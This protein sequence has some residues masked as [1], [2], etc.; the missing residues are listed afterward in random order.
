M[1]DEELERE[2]KTLNELAWEDRVPSKSLFDW[3]SNFSDA[4]FPI[5]E[6]IQ[7]SYALFLLSRFMYFGDREIR[8]LLKCLYR[9]L[10][11]YTLIASIRRK[12]SNTIDEALIES[13]FTNERCNTRFLGIG[14]PSESGSHLLYYF[15]Q[16][17]RLPKSL[18][19]HSH[20][21][22]SRS[23]GGLRSPQEI[24][25]ANPNV[26]R[27][28][29][30]DDLCASGGQVRSYATSLIDLIRNLDPDV[31]MHYFA[32][33]GN[34]DALESIQR[35]VGFNSARS[36]MELDSTFKAFASNSR[37]FEPPNAKYPKNAIKQL[38]EYYG[39]KLEPM[40]PLGFGDC[41]YMLGFHHNTPDNSL[42]IFWYDESPDRSWFPIFRRYPKI[43]A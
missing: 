26:R 19:I 12:N 29:F 34:P 39:Q 33:F 4:G 21:I 28:V 37:I 22:F 36:V 5:N 13:E 14:N 38:S 43:Y 24:K 1:I 42:P 25:L 41:Q 6:D 27:Y 7:K 8:E 23:S 35:D 31:E 3:L 9:D 30:I 17:N 15:R 32:L 16:E 11:R 2:I 40:Q 10:Y 20:E 18:F